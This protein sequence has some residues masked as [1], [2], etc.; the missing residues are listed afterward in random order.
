MPGVCPNVG[1]WIIGPGR[2]A[3]ADAITIVPWR[4]YCYY[5][6]RRI[7]E[8]S[9]AGAK[10]WV[11]YMRTKFTKDGLYEQPTWGDWV[12]VEPTNDRYV[13]AC[14]GYYSTRLLAETAAVLGKQ[15]EAKRYGELAERQ[16]EA[17][18]GKFLDRSTGHYKPET[19][20][21]NL[22]PL[23]FSITPSQFRQSVADYVA[24]DVKARGNRH[25]TGFLGSAV[26][27]PTLARY[28]YADLAWKIT[29]SD[30]YPSLGYMVRKGATTVWERWNSDKMGPEMNSRNHFAFGSM[31]QWLFE[32][33]AGINVDPARPG[34][35]HIIFKPY[36]AGGLDW[37]RVEYESLYG[38]VASRW[39]R[40]G[41]SIEWQVTVPPNTTA[42]AYIPAEKPESVRE[43]GKP[44]AEAEGVKLA[45]TEDG[46]VV[47]TL[48]SGTYSFQIATD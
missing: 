31:A 18:N 29:S 33:L 47:V 12:P 39:K 9:Y 16:A 17:F 44:I 42:S 13:A 25:T 46:R 26:I 19:Q 8:E 3:W 34:F 15:D 43:S 36:L 37:V 45:G 14:Y 7:L 48:A 4:I 27:L 35:K 22:L 2:S 41:R 32:G 10:R 21:A 20:T 38:T 1:D 40:A 30:Q 23:A 6:D 5:G 11:E 28:G 24:Q